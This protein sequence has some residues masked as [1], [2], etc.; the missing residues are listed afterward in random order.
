MADT[1][2][3]D[4]TSI[5]GQILSG[6]EKLP[7]NLVGGPVDV[8]NVILNA[9]GVKTNDTPIGGSKWLGQLAATASQKLGLG[10]ASNLT[11]DT[12]IA[13]TATQMIGGLASPGSTALAAVK[14]GTIAKAMVVPAIAIKSADEVQTAAR[15]LN[16]GADAQAVYRNSGIFQGLEE[17]PTYKAVIPDTGASLNT[18]T[19]SLLRDSGPNPYYT[20]PAKLMSDSVQIN[21]NF[22]GKLP[23]ILDHPDLYNA[24]PQL[25]DVNV[26]HDPNLATG[27]AYYIPGNNTISVGTHFGSAGETNIDGTLKAGDRTGTTAFLSSVLHETQ[28]A[29]QNI[30]GFAQGGNPGMFLR[31]S[32]DELPFAAQKAKDAG[33]LPAAKILQDT[34]NKA[35]D[36]YQN[37][38]GELEAKATEKQFQTKD[39]SQ[40]PSIIQDNAAR[41]RNGGMVYIDPRNNPGPLL[42]DDPMIQA[43]LVKYAYRKP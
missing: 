38:A 32:R 30:Y 31:G 5:L 3:D 15:F 2:T 18:S 13:D 10:D 22:S 20:G 29:V 42:D 17:Q 23:D 21:P 14:L 6:V 7:Q 41:T 24:I 34:Y 26:K 33:D 36:K 27:N 37:I 43:L 8:A 40:P 28:H 25:K 11:K 35:V 1:S 12:G 39:Y 4:G 9:A 19:G 16:K